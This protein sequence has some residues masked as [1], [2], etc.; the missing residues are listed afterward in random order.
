MS[1]LFQQLKPVLVLRMELVVFARKGWN[2]P[3]LPK[4]ETIVGGLSFA[5]SGSKPRNPSSAKPFVSLDLCIRNRKG[6]KYL[7]CRM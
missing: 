7:Y 2:C 5:Q 3:D 4:A 1:L 6:P